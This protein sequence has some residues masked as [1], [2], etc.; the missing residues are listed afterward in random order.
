MNRTYVVSFDMSKLCRLPKSV[1][2]PVEVTHPFMK[3]GITSSNIPYVGLE[4]LNI[5]RVETHN[6]GEKSDICLGDLLPIIEWS[7]AGSQM[8]LGPIKIFKKWVKILL[9]SFLGRCKSGFVDAV[10]DCIVS[11]IVGVFDV[12]LEMFW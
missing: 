9:I 2:V 11:P 1:D 5:Y 7:L 6:G 8:L 12:F 10:V 3:C 4:M